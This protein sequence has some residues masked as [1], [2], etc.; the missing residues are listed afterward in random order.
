MKKTSK[1]L[2]LF[3]VL[4]VLVSVFCMPISAA[5]APQG[6]TATVTFTFKDIAGV[7]GTISY[8]NADIFADVKVRVASNT[9]GEATKDAFFLYSDTAEAGNLSFILTVKIDP[10]AK[11]NESCTIAL[12]FDTYDEEGN[13]IAEGLVRTETVKV[14]AAD[15]VDTSYLEEQIALAEAL[16]AKNYTIESWTVLEAALSAAKSARTSNSQSRIDGAAK[17]L[18]DARLALVRLDYSKLVAALAEVNTFYGTDETT[19]LLKQ[20]VEAVTEGNALLENGGSQEAI[21]ATAAKILELL[22]ALKA[23]LDKVGETVTI[24]VPVVE[25]T[26][27]VTEVVTE[28]ITEVE[29]PADSNNLWLILFIVTAIL[30]VALV[31]VVVVLFVKKNNAEKDMMDAPGSDED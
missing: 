19:G 13:V 12:L 26:E 31:V 27:V 8:S 2:A 9:T 20:F 14:V 22:E 5:N 17:T 30:L 4:S 24:Q 6:K 18:E 29:V 28:V 21:N 25:Q 7:N 10:K 11:I 1:L 3:L 15:A 16:V 23:A